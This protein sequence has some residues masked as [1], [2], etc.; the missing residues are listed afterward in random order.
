MFG[1]VVYMVDGTLHAILP[2]AERA[3]V[4]IL[5]RLDPVTDYLASAMCAYRSEF[6]DRTFEAIENMAVAGRNHF[7]GKIIIVTAYLAACHF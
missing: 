3:T 4:I 6:M 2:R 5:V 1:V 7:E